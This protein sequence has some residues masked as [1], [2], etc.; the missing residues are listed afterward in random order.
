MANAEILA[1]NGVEERPV[2][3][4]SFDNLRRFITEGAVAPIR[5]YPADV[6]PDYSDKRIYYPSVKGI[7]LQNWKINLR[8]T[9]DYVFGQETGKEIGR[10]EGVTKEAIRKTVYNTIIRLHEGAKDSDRKRFPFESFDFA[11]PLSLASRQRLSAARGGM[12]LEIAKKL[13]QG[14]TLNELKKDYT[15]V[16]LGRSRYVLESWGY[17]LKR[18]NN[19]ILPQFEGLRNPDAT[20]EEIQT[21]LDK[22]RTLSQNRVLKKAGLVIDLTTVAKT[23]GLYFDPRQV[24]IISQS[25]AIEKL[26][27]T[28]VAHKIKDK[29]GQEGI[30]YYHILAA[31]D[32]PDAIDILARDHNLDDLRINPVTQIAGPEEELLPNTTQL[33]S[34]KYGSVGNLISEIRGVRWNGI[35]KGGI[36]TADII[37]GSHVVIYRNDRILYRKDQEGELRDYVES[38]LREL[39]M[40]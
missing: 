30:A 7:N 39:G 24:N 13:E 33:G 40:I 3:G 4:K 14:A 37:K 34:N 18:E 16:Q 28:K 1:Q 11:K 2:E 25:L 20:N 6:K 10:R 36:L 27:Q 21:L 31:K 17:E 8:K 23:A 29:N 19:P 38:R 15:A 5:I 35:G 12:S 22:I 9:Y 26:P 32:Q